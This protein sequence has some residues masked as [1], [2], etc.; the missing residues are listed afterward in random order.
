MS[1][2]VDFIRL[3]GI[4]FGL[5]QMRTQFNYPKPDKLDSVWFSKYIQLYY[6]YGHNIQSGS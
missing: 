1:R 6:R 2:G 4:N 5:N 3:S